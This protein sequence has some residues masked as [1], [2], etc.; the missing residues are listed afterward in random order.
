M[1]A[2]IVPS[3]ATPVFS[4]AIGCFTGQLGAAG[5]HVLLGLS[6]WAAGGEDGLVAAILG[7]QP[8]GLLLTGVARSPAT[9]RR[10][11]AAGLP[12]VEIWDSTDEP[13]DMLVGFDHHEVGAAVAGHFL[14]QGH[15]RFAAIAADEPRALARCA[16]FCDTVRRHG[17][18]VVGHRVY[19]PTLTPLH[20]REGVR[21]MLPALRRDRTAIMC[22]SDLVALGAIVEAQAQGIAVPDVLAVCGFGDLDASRGM[23]PGITTVSVDGT[24]IGHLAAR[25]LLDRFAGRPGP[26]GTTVPF[27]MLVRGSG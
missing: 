10:L 8:E 3:I 25:C 11:A 7:R 12:V 26:R 24:Q 15:R 13:A 23:E 19:T 27:R 14:A 16:G 20:G 2:A 6:G 9:R 4:S 18:E 17:G 1:I 21:D 22:S 5:Y